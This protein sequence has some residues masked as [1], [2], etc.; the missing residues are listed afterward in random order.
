MTAV[1]YTI[2]VYVC[3]QSCSWTAKLPFLYIF[4]PLPSGYKFS[5]CTNFYKNLADGFARAG[6]KGT[7][8]RPILPCAMF[9]MFRKIT[10]IY[11]CVVSRPILTG[12][13]CRLLKTVKNTT[14]NAKSKASCSANYAAVRNSLSC[15]RELFPK[16]KSLMF[17]D[18]DQRS[19]TTSN[20]CS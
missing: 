5:H 9:P 2:C 14:S 4:S 10:S 15:S 6:C 20:P 16:G 17:S 19:P 13:N 11:K 18:A 8:R 7:F 12:P 1:A 3:V